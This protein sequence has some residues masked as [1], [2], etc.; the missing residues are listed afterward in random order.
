MGR[1]LDTRRV[2]KPRDARWLLAVQAGLLTLAA[3]TFAMLPPDKG[4][5]L[6]VSLT[7]NSM[8]ALLD[9]DM[10]LLGE[11]RLPGSLIVTGPHPSFLTTLL[12]HGVLVL[13]A[14]PVLCGTPQILEK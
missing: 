9:T 1:L 14:L 3:L 12:D 10:R 2:A 4:A 11:G 7:G 6:L 5:V 13:P 8:P